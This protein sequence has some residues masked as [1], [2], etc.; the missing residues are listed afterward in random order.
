MLQERGKLLELYPLRAQG[1]GK[2]SDRSM[3]SLHFT[4]LDNLQVLAPKN[5][6]VPYFNKIIKV[7]FY[8]HFM[9]LSNKLSSEAPYVEA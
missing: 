8:P 6:L 3:F 9:Y 5:V 2:I 7:A 1:D 4:I